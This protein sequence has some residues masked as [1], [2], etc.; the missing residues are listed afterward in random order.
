MKEIKWNIIHSYIEFLAL[1]SAI[2]QFLRTLS[3]C[4]QA[5]IDNDFNIAI[6]NSVIDYILYKYIDID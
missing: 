5:N 1:H 4:F 6:T 2:H 3:V